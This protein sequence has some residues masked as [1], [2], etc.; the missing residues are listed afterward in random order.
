MGRTSLIRHRSAGPSHYDWEAPS[1]D[2][3]NEKNARIINPALTRILRGHGT[4]S[5]VDFAC[6]TGSQVLWLASRGFRVTGVDISPAM[7]KIARRKSRRADLRR[8]DM[9]TARVGT[10]DAALTISNAVGHLTRRDFERAMRNIRGNLAP[11]GLYVF[12]IYNLEWLRRRGN[13]EKLTIDWIADGIR[14]VQYSTLD[15]QGVLTSFTTVMT[16]ARVS[17]NVSTL[18]LYT[19]RE[20]KIMLRR[21]GF[22]RM[23]CLG[24]N[25]APFSRTRTDRLLAVALCPP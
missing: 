1:Y 20:L 16:G 24:V 9:R 15:S 22:G 8:G 25:G 11:G 2:R 18:Q 13:L 19:A 5:V 12:D 23:R 3:F 7:L 10:F 4:K 21:N 6:G 17:R 14:H